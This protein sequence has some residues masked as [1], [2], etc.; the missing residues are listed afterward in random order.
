MNSWNYSTYSKVDP[1]AVRN[2]PFESPRPEQIETISEITDAIGRGY[3][4]IVLEAGTG[5][6]KSAIAKTLTD[7]YDES[8]ILTSTKQLQDQYL[9]DFD[10]I[11]LV[12]GRSNFNC[13]H[14]L[15]RDCSMGKCI[16][17]GH[18]CRFSLKDRDDEITEDNTCPY[19]YQKYL[20]L[21]SRCV[22]SNYHYMILELNYVKDF[23][24]RNLL[25]CDEAHNLE[26][27]LMDRLTLEFSKSD[28][29]EY[30]N[31]DLTEELLER[32]DSQKRTCWLDFGGDIREAY[33]SELIRIENLDTPGLASRIAFIRNQISDCSRFMAHLAT[34][35]DVWIFDWDDES[36]TV[37]FKPLK[38]DNYA[39]SILFD[40]ADAVI[41]MS[42]TIL[43]YGLF[44]EWLGI[45]EGEI[46]PIRR[47]SPFDI[48]KNPIKTFSD[49]NLSSVYI[50]RN[51]IRSL[52]QIREILNAHRDEKGIVH[53]VSGRCRDFLAENL[54]SDRL[55]THNTKDKVTRLDEFKS[56]NDPL[57]LVS[58]SLGE[59]VDLP[60][61]LCRFQIIYKIPFPDWG[62]R[63]IQR[64][65]SIDPLWYSY[66]TALNLVQFHG[67]GMRFEDDYCM[68][69]VIDSRF[70]GYVM[71][72]PF[73]P[74]TFR[75]AIKSSKDKREK[76]ELMK[77]GDGLV[78]SGEYERAIVFFNEL[79]GNDLFFN[80]DYP[81]V[82]LSKIY[83]MA[84]MYE[85]EIEII[86]R[87]MKSGFK[88]EYFDERLARL[89]EMG[90]YARM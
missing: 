33:I 26:S 14:Y 13:L 10:G 82:Q 83:E 84:E 52:D 6:G 48:S 20:A 58:P 37:Q 3:K 89:E 40:H 57:V 56:S 75:D 45:D 32:L 8:Y 22:I 62:D 2:F 43:D 51:S 49:Y 79:L 31:L 39:K 76:L 17:E 9:R 28:L 53:T 73:I 59:G 19:Y 7:I 4:Y 16:A 61:D 54:D 30:L 60:G 42:A 65:V 85:R 81:Y 46:Y 36:E 5:T 70:S 23:Q 64:R 77:R 88:S 11:T 87:F 67:R 78:E 90:Y 29:K 1:E 35:P 12:K 63:Q 50:E 66:R 47:K 25:I 24:K 18:R 86:M 21:N 15:A 69:Y 74:D 44:A 72:N 71:T 55:I 80:D 68:T 38:V 27:T 34:D 41:L